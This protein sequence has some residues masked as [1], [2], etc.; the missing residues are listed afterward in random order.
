MFEF[1]SEREKRLW[2][3]TL[4]VVLA[5]YSTLA[6]AG[7]LTDVWRDAPW[8]VDFFFFSFS[9]VGI[10]TLLVG[11]RIRPGGR[12]VGVFLGVVAV[13]VMF[14]VRIVAS[15]AERTHLFEYSIVGAL[16]Y[17]ALLERQS[18]S[19][20][21]AAPALRA[22]LATTL[23]GV[24]DEALQIYLPERYFDPIDILF[25]FLAGLLAVLAVA[26]LNRARDN[27]TR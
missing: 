16:I 9:S 14:G 3:A 21:P 1:H 25:N 22:I 4:L 5:I 17:Q 19:G 18:H 24:L 11:L 12:E 27:R 2:I 8:L 6:L 26:V 15:V 20:S 13:Y 7:R 23:I 10:A